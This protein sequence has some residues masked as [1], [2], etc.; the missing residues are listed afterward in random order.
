[1][2]RDIGRILRHGVEEEFMNRRGRYLVFV[3]SGLI[4]LSGWSGLCQADP[5]GPLVADFAD[6]QDPGKFALQVFPSI[7][8]RTGEFDQNG[9]VR[10]L[11]GGDRDY[12]LVVPVV[13]LYGIVKDLE[14]SGEIPFIYNWK[15]QSGQSAQEG[16]IGDA[17][18]KMKYRLFDGGE[19]GWTPSVS[20]VGRVRFPTGKYEK[21]APE[22]MGV[23][24]T[25]SGSYMY[26]LGVNVG[27]WTKKW[28]VTA[29]LWYNWPQETT[30]D[31]VKTREGNFWFY[32]LAGEYA[33]TEN[34]SVILEFYGQEQGKTEIESRGVDNSESRVL[35]VLPGVGWDIS[36]KM[37]LMAGCSFPLLGKN[38]AHTIIPTLFFNYCF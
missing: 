32:A 1:M 29:N 14:I 15:S 13:P 10:Y 20:T 12:S 19:E 21:L 11:P 34:W 35:Y 9:N 18:L 8:I 4:F 37:F 33:L 26:S 36:K 16:N 23:E 17:A 2:A 22:K 30:I 3:F 31:G 25:G 38:N 24:K 28:Q 7:A 27:K 6:T 5:V